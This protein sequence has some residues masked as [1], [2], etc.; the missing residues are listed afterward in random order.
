MMQTRENPRHVE[1]QVPGMV[2]F[3]GRNVYDLN[4]Q[5]ERKMNN[6]RVLDTA[7]LAGRIML[8][9]GAETYRIEDTMTHILKIAE[10][11]SSEVFVMTTGIVATLEAEGE[12]PLT[13]VKRITVRST[14]MSHIVQ[15]ND[16]SR[17]LCS[18][19][20]SMDEAYKE[21]TNLKNRQYPGLAYRIA[22]VGVVLGF[23]VMLG[24]NE[25]DA[26][27]GVIVGIVLSIVMA[28]GEKAEWNSF[29][30]DAV[31]STAICFLTYLL[32]YALPFEF[33][34][35]TVIIGAIMPL[36]PGVALTN[37]VRDSLQGDLI[38]GGARAMEAFLKAVA[39][40]VGISIG[41]I[42]YKHVN[43]G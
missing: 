39:I 43:L 2:D 6:Q 19:W 5:Q 27:I 14:N 11:C 8:E 21:L 25:I 12:P 18:G 22:V 3:F 15:V 10:D 13:K 17:R 1:K 29:I 41:M 16:I 42:F 4:E 30:S 32:D 7:M 34:S 9:S 20:I 36:V 23:V 40:A 35:S 38:S 24:G 26:M 37:A 31:S 33:N 28:I